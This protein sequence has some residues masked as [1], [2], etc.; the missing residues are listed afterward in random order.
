MAGHMIPTDA[1]IEF[2][3]AP[4]TLV[5]EGVEALLSRT[6]LLQAALAQLR[7][8]GESAQIGLDAILLTAA[9]IEPSGCILQS[10]ALGVTVQV[11]RFG[12]TFEDGHHKGG[13]WSVFL[14]S[15]R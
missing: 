12:C 4:V 6:P 15:E 11:E 13:E 8:C 10:K 14:P 7:W 2:R 3:G 9:D 5:S 1:K